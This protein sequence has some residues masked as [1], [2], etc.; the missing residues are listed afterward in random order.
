MRNSTPSIGIVQVIT[1]KLWQKPFWQQQGP[2]EG[3]LADMFLLRVHTRIHVV[4]SQRVA[5]SLS[6]ECVEFDR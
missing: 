1:A 3:N 6:L 2:P 5:A 4:K